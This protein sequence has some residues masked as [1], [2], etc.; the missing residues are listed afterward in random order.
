MPLSRERVL[1]AAVRLAD[2]TGIEALSMRNLADAL[3]VKAMSLYNHVAGKDDVLDGMVDLV[4]GE[5]ELPTAGADWKAAM[6]RRAISAHEVLMHHPWATMLIVSRINVGPAML[7]YMEATL[8]C[9]REAGFSSV[10]ADHAWNAIDSFIHGFTLQK[11]NFPL[12]PADYA[13]AAEQFLPAIPAEQY[14]YAHE[15]ARQVIDGDHD[16][17]NDLTF[18][19]DLILDGLDRLR[20]ED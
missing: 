13:S 5:I 3:G 8:G 9:L 2:E 6:R 11:L 20:G 12:R 10:E 19:L 4:V 1:R 15:L 17:L 14:P 16:G 18:G 7:R